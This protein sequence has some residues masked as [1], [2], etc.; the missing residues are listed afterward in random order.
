M[1]ST[2]DLT[3]V[4]WALNYVKKVEFTL[5]QLIAVASSNDHKKWIT[6]TPYAF[7]SIELSDYSAI[8]YIETKPTLYLR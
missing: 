2:W 6:K 4:A 1:Y 5:Y 3:L 8:N 7:N